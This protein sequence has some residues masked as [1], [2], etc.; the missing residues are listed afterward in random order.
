MIQKIFLKMMH[1]LKIIYILYL[2]TEFFF[3]FLNLNKFIYSIIILK[4]I[5]IYSINIIKKYNNK[6]IIIK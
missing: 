2:F 3:E 4:N 6:N 5:F 1:V